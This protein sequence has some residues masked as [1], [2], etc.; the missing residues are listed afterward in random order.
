MPLTVIAEDSTSAKPLI[1]QTIVYNTAKASEVYL[2]WDLDNW[3]TVPE[4]QF[5]P[6]GTFLKKGMAWSPMQ[7]N[8]DSFSISI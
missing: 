7:G 6:K 1:T 2:V 4:K 3:K 5:W 8:K